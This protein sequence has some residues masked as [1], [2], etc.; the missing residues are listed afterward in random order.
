MKAALYNVRQSCRV[1]LRVSGL[2][3]ERL[4]PKGLAAPAEE[5]DQI[6]LEHLVRIGLAKRKP[7]K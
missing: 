7:V 4:F 3:I 1:E 5:G 6:A 2:V